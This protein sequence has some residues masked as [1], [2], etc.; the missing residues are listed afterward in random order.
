MSIPK[1]R[2]STGPPSK[3]PRYLGQYLGHGDNWC[4]VDYR[5]SGPPL[6]DLGI[7]SMVLVMFFVLNQAG[8]PQ[9]T[10][11][12]CGYYIVTF[13]FFK[14]LTCSGEAGL[15]GGFFVFQRH[16]VTRGR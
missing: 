4:P 1:S 2:F 10:R 3:W 15:A 14:L 13:F 6:D 16:S 9:E 8:L 5:A 7:A 11:A 12:V